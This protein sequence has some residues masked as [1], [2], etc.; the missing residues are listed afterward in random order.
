MTLPAYMTDYPPGKGYRQTG[1][2]TM[3][4]CLC[5]KKLST[6]ALARSGHDKGDLCQRRQDERKSRAVAE[7]LKG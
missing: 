2:G 3:A 7:E 5:G 6:N 4:C 1:P